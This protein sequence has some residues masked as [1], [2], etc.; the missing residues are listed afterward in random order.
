MFS[1]R[2]QIVCAVMVF[3]VCTGDMNADAQENSFA[4]R[5]ATVLPAVGP[6]VQ[7]G[8]ILVEDGK[9]TAA[10]SR[11]RIPSGVRVIDVS[12]KVIT[13]GFI[14]THSHLGMFYAGD[15]NEGPMP[16]GPEN[17]ALDAIHLDIPDWKQAYEGG[18]T[19]IVTGPGS[20]ERMGGQ[21]ITI[22]TFGDDLDKRILKESGELKM[23]VNARDLTYIPEI[24]SKLLQ[25]QE[26]L[27]KWDE[28]KSG[29]GN[30]EPPKRDLTL[31]A[32]S[33]ALT[34]EVPIRVHIYYVNDMMSFLK[35]KDEFGF[36]LQFIHSVEA[37]K[38]ADEIAKRDVGCICLPLGMRYSAS[39]DQLRGNTVLH[40]AGVTVALHTDHPVIM[41]KNFRLCA[42][43][44]IRYGMPA[45]AALKALTINAAKL[46]GIEDRVG[47]IETGKDADL[48]V[49]NG[50]WHELKSRVDMVFVDG[51]IAFDR[52]NQEKELQ[53]DK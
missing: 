30:G 17:R 33:K 42:M 23:A 44:C 6:P 32:L 40:N 3:F 36:D 35:L 50:P 16:Y 21:S 2:C 24:H 7:N 4:L 49:F 9:I 43:M 15:V 8:I 37:Y 45:A 27:K 19:V 18:T 41:Q 51:I 11:V 46:A 48:V 52:S 1:I 13:P 25:S 10:G 39:D 12:G 34:G 47:S 29:G 53:E 14:D 20:G 22:K 31:E 26:Y 38:I 5:G 28:Y